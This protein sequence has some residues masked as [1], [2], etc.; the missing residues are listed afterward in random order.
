M[1]GTYDDIYKTIIQHFRREVRH[2][3]FYAYRRRMMD[4]IG[5]LADV[6]SEYDEFCLRAR[7]NG[8]NVVYIPHTNN[9]HLRPVL[10]AKKQFRQGVARYYLPQY[11]LVKT[12][13]H[14]FLHIKPH[15]FAGYM[16]ARSM[17][18][19]RQRIKVDF[20]DAE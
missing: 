6:I 8:W 17:D 18:L 9:L 7:R 10:T 20:D 14:S 5:G 12:F 13:L 15:L 11:D 2:T 1:M 4:K 3:G 16:H 19:K